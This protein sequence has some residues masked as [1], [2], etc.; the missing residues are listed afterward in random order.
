M[1]LVGHERR[2]GG[3]GRI[4]CLPGLASIRRAAAGGLPC[5][6][7]PRA[8]IPSSYGT[9]FIRSRGSFPIVAGWPMSDCLP[10]PN[11]S[12]PVPG[13]CGRSAIARRRE[14]RP[15]GRHSPTSPRRG[16]PVAA[17][18]QGLSP[19]APR[20]QR[21]RRRRGSTRTTADR[22][23]LWFNVMLERTGRKR[24]GLFA[25]FAAGPL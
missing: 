23:A 15:P 14:C 12:P 5:A 19:R 6:G 3:I 24:R 17:A 21:A 7:R 9:S 22:A 2:K 13:C 10:F 16:I 11:C 18:A 20:R 25:S 1:N 8:A 4:V